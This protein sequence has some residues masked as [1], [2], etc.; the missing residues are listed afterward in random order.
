MVVSR[1]GGNHCRKRKIKVLRLERW[2]YINC[3][4]AM[5]K[6]L[7]FLTKKIKTLI[8]T[9]LIIVPV[10]ALT[11]PALA[12]T[13]PINPWGTDSI[14]SNISEKTGLGEKDPRIVAADIIRVALGFL[15]IIAVMIILFGGFKWMTAGGNED[16]VGEAKKM[17]TAGV[18]GLVIILASFAIASFVLKNLVNVTTS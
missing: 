6:K 9:W 16:G 14:R 7:M 10:F 18:I 12:L 3:H 11:L 17:I 2:K 5:T 1:L 4:S 8:L 13:N 15:G